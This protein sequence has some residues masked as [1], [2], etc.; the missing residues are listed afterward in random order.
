MRHILKELM[1]EFSNKCKLVFRAKMSITKCENWAILVKYD[2][3]LSVNSQIY[4]PEN[5]TN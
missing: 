2:F 1:Y 4:S 3:L 5:E